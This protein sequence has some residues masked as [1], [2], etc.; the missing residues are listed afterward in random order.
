M[1]VALSLS[2]TP[3]L[4][5][6]FDDVQN[7]VDGDTS[8]GV[9]IEDSEKANHYGYGDKNEDTG[10]Y[11][12]ESWGDAASV[13]GRTVQL[14]E[15]VTKE[16]GTRSGIEVGAEDGNVS[17]DLNGNDMVSDHYD[18]EEGASD[19]GT[20]ALGK[21]Y[22]SVVKVGQ[23]ASL[24][25]KDTSSEET[26]KQGNISGGFGAWDG[27]GGVQVD[28]GTVN[29]E[30]GNISNNA[31]YV[32]G[33]GI[34]VKNGGTLHMSGGSVHDN[35]NGGIRISGSE[36]AFHMT[37][38]T[39]TGNNGQGVH[40]A[41]G[42]QVTLD[43]GEITK[44]KNSGIYFE[45]G[46]DLTMN[47]GLIAE[48]TSNNGAGVYLNDHPVWK[49]TASMTMNGGT[50]RDNKSTVYGGG[51]YLE[52]RSTLTL[53]DGL[54]AGNEAGYSG[55][56]IGGGSVVMDGG[57]IT[58]NRAHHFGGGINSNQ[59]TMENG[60]ITGNIAE[61][62][63]GGGVSA[64]DFTMNDG[65]IQGNSADYGGGLNV[66]R[67]MRL[68]GGTIA[69]NIATGSEGGGIH[70]A[71]NGVI[72]AQNGNVSIRGN[73][74]LTK[75]DLGGGGIYVNASGRLELM[76]VVITQ[77]TAGTMGGGLAACH[78]G[79]NFVYATDG[80]AI[81]DN[82]ANGVALETYFKVNNDV[83][84]G[85][86]WKSWT[87]AQRKLFMRA[88]N[89]IFTAGVNGYGD[90]Y[91]RDY[92][93]GTLFGNVMLGYGKQMDDLE[94]MT[95]E[96]M[97]DVA[98]HLS[99]YTGYR[100]SVAEP[101]KLNE[102]DA[103]NN[104][105]IYSD[106]FLVLTAHPSEEGKRAAM[107][108]GNVFI[109]D[110]EAV[111]NDG[112]GIANNGILII[113]K[114]TQGISTMPD[115]FLAKTWLNTE[116]QQN[117]LKG[118]D[119]SFELKGGQVADENGQA[120]ENAERKTLKVKNDAEGNAAFEMFNNGFLTKPG[121]Y[122][123]TLY[124]NR[125]ESLEKARLRFDQ[126]EYRITLN[127]RIE[128]KTGTIAH[129]P[130]KVKT[131]VLD[132]CK[133]ERTKDAEG[134]T[135]ETPET[136]DFKTGDR[137]RFE[138]T[139]R[140]EE[141]EKPVDPVDPVDPIDPFEPEFPVEPVDLVNPDDLKKTVQPEEPSKKD[142]KMPEN[143]TEQND[144]EPHRESSK[145]SASLVSTSTTRQ[146]TKASGIAR[147]STTKKSPNTGV[148][149]MTKLHENLIA[150]SGLGIAGLWFGRKKKQK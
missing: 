20:P 51:I 53:N 31:S 79:R 96:Q 24:T 86:I 17:L 101:D 44:N 85:D 38:G 125:D 131:L 61:E 145:K 5:A 30:G 142:Q 77:N 111:Y 94:N 103:G 33:G 119:F 92:N 75:D 15:D 11:G 67:Q 47:G 114:E 82:T 55:G 124:E 106:R 144:K 14:Y 126:S 150:L 129:K 139:T 120:I 132:S 121:T 7:A 50:I 83:D 91:N 2:C 97:Q 102:V 19:N 138:N 137:V 112:G 63:G 56:G 52:G 28:G 27:D 13:D 89:D 39:I 149:L 93:A 36:S 146:K 87:P 109:T 49:N 135:L 64:K 141:P 59:V 12:V 116:G 42:S 41:N 60:S 115:V 65:L 58:R 90:S 3:A 68:H 123:F 105:T 74:T 21:S 76:N 48:N 23:D 8:A 16:D 147:A 46:G 118:D 71:G 99:N 95:T 104:G 22:G 148:S 80:G 72:E 66:S 113:G 25:I 4:A 18:P 1:A 43:N 88:A 117:E 133:V 57:T 110:N 10:Y 78:T 143:P 40:V 9:W 29:L 84:G 54:I 73:K 100:V 134:R 37:G 122:Q 107:E 98:K 127:T 62:H 70:L 128:E 81:F 69:D 32:D 26:E 45:D 6:S 136:L 35:Q 34:G 108:N 140:P 130:Y